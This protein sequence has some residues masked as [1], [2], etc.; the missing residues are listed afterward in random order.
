MPIFQIYR[1]FI[2]K[3]QFIEVSS[4]DKLQPIRKVEEVRSL[5]F[6]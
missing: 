3:L 1:L 6:A 2:N 4:D 5:K